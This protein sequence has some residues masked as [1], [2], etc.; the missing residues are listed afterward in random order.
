MKKA[1]TLNEIYKV[2]APEIYPN[3]DDQDFYVDLYKNDLIRFVNELNEN[4]NTKQSFFIAGQSGNGKSTVLNLLDTNHPKLKDK[5]EFKYMSG[6]EIFKYED[7]NIIDLLLMIGGNLI[8]DN[9]ILQKKYFEE[10]DK[11]QD[12]SNGTL[13][14]DTIESSQKDKSLN[15]DTSVGFKIKFLNIFESKSTIEASY[16]M[17]N[18]LRDV[19]RRVFKTKESDLIELI[20]SIILDYKEEQN[21]NKDLLIIIDDLEKKENIDQLFL[22]ELSHLDSINMVKIITMPI[23]LRRTQTFNSKD[24]REFALK[25]NDFKGKSNDPDKKLLRQVIENRIENRDL[26]D[27]TTIDKAVLKSGGNLR[28]LI[29]LVRI[30]ANEALSFEA[31]QIADKEIEYAI[32]SLQRGLSSPTMMMQTFLKEILDEKIIKD[33]T[34]ES[35]AKLGKAIKMGLVFAYFN[36]KIWYEINPLIKDILIDYTKTT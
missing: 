27:T 9:K 32:E 30:S 10:L 15:A 21:T 3:K 25:L 33:D 7:I 34:P 31:P 11:I 17:N 8:K 2:F 1:T 24:V 5:Y 28:Q 22:K 16:K 26:I 13:Q 12:V 23:H 35:L 29:R 4:E 19:A 36:G 20:N 18:S 6:K 14:I